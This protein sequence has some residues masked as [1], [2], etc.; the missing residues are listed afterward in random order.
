M[1]MALSMPI[2]ASAISQCAGT[3]IFTNGI[4]DKV[5]LP[6][7]SNNSG[8]TNCL[9]GQGD[10]SPAVTALQNALDTCYSA[11]LT[12]D[13]KFGALT[14]EALQDAQSSEGITADGVYGPVTRDHL[15][16]RNLSGRTRCIGLDG[17][18]A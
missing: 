12:Q 4:G 5:Q 3:T 7:T 9:L 8:N 18:P 1:G 2:S 6:T 10:A 16:W 17:N 11:G 15:D 13:G 14:A